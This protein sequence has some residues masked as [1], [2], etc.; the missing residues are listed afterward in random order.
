MQEASQGEEL[1]KEASR[2]GSR[3]ASNEMGVSKEGQQRLS[4]H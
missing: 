2:K 3:M 1:L 4:Q